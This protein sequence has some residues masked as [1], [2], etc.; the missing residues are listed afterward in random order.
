MLHPAPGPQSELCVQV[1][2][3]PPLV[4]APNGFEIPGQAKDPVAVPHMHEPVVGLMVLAAA[5]QLDAPLL[6]T[7]TERIAPPPPDTQTPWLV[8][9]VTFN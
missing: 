7:Q 6:T 4:P 8:L 1:Q 5:R 2:L 9:L 3:S